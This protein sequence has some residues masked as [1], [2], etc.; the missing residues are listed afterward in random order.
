[1]LLFFSQLFV[2]LPQTAILPF[3]IFFPWGWS[4]LLPPVQ[5][6]KPPSIVLQALYQIGSLESICH[7]YCIVIRDLIWV[8]P[9]WSSGFPYFLPFKSEFCNKEFMIWATVSSRSCFCWLYRASSSL[10]AENI[11]NLNS[12]MSMCS[13]LLCCS[14]RVFALTSAFSWEN[15]VNL[16]LALFCTP[17]PNLPVTP[18]ISWLPTFPFQSPIMKR[19]SFL[20][21]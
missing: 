19:T 13:L 3:C 18:G 12:V 16:W 20:G 17:R 14:K 9:E 4:W 15:S 5:C 8:T 2:S 1:L 10:A 21:G 7:F 11:I 6:H